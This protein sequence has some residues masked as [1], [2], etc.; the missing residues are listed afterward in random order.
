MPL[1]VTKWVELNLHTLTEK[2]QTAF[3]GNSLPFQGCQP[4]KEIDRCRQD[5]DEYNK[6]V[7]HLR[8]MIAVL[9]TVDGCLQRY[10]WNEFR[11]TGQTIF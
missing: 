11:Y 9:E 3:A 7:T 8:G 2:H 5:H 6:W 10:F 4:G 1:R